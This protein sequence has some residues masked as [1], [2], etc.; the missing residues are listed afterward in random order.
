LGSWF[1]SP[2]PLSTKPGRPNSAKFSANMVAKSAL[3]LVAM[4]VA[5]HAAAPAPRPTMSDWK[6]VQEEKKIAAGGAAAKESKMA[7]VNKVTELL[8]GLREQV[9][10][11][12][13][14]EATMYNEFAC[15]CKDTTSNK[16]A[17]IIAGKD[18]VNV[19][20]TEIN[21]LRA[22]RDRLDTTI[23]GLT[24]DIKTAEATQ[25]ELKSTRAS[26]LKEYSANAQDLTMALESLE[27]AIEALKASKAP[28]PSLL[29]TIKKAAL[30]ADALGVSSSTLVQRAVAFVQQAPAVEME[31]YKYHSD[32]II[33]TLEKLLD[34]FR[35]EKSEVDTAEVK[36]VS[37]YEKAYQ[38]EQDL[39]EMKTTQ[40]GEAKE[41]RQARVED[42]EETAG[43]LT[44]VSAALR[45]DQ[46][47]LSALTDMCSHRARTWDQRSTLRQ[48]EIEVLT[49]AIG[50]ITSTVNEKTIAATVRFAQTGASLD[51]AKAVAANP[52]A[53]EAVEAEVERSSAPA[54][55]QEGSRT[56]RRL[57]AH[58]QAPVEAFV[59]SEVSQPNRDAIV[60]LLKKSGS[61]LHSKILSALA[62]QIADDPFA[63]VKQLI[64]ELLE[65]LLQEA[66]EQGNQK[67]WCDKSLKAA[68]QKRDY[69]AAA[70]RT[71]NGK[72]AKLEAEIDQLTEE[73]EEVAAAIADLNKRRT[74]AQADRDADHTENTAT[75]TTAEE[76]QKA[77]E[78]AIEILERF[79]KT[80]AV[81]QTVS[82][83]QRQAPMEDAPD[84]G[85]D[86]G[87]QYVGAQGAAGG[88][89]SML[90]VIQG[91]FARTI[92]ETRKAEA[93][94]EK[95]HFE[96]MTETSKSLA[97][98]DEAHKDAMSLFNDAS[99]KHQ[100]ASDSLDA[101]S[102]LLQTSIA[103]LLELQPVCIDTGMTYADRVA[104]RREEI[105]ALKEA[106]SIL[107]SYQEYGPAM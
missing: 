33:E 71:L 105:A 28:T 86:G 43:Q 88:I 19:L 36:S 93:Q 8:K 62:N 98:K 84:S 1:A 101:E 57:R 49:Q 52:S 23:Q 76:G 59:Q 26:D 16:N 90:K 81:E 103:E 89:I 63:K 51:A 14:Q 5:A 82:M 24:N 92:K 100:A 70:I 56:V 25:A 7:A 68:S 11:E 13:E 54:F 77:V 69:A 97:E 34:D 18:R 99:A 64:Q 95:D 53:M 107:D 2:S 20:T 60:S 79:Y 10:A 15:F 27:G 32:D 74:E 42:I 4:V 91:D 45:E 30:T 3:V 35:Q 78:N 21:S 102:S 6:K 38:N 67:G 87:E 17:A 106:L 94:A 73:L 9:L 75:I 31:N 22:D 39:I 37:E 66:A 46:E 72:M 50:I 12:G 85:F 48:G 40:L 61:K 44:D 83:A 104:N 65:R 96:F 58:G 29:E 47:Y 80:A 55:V 41:E